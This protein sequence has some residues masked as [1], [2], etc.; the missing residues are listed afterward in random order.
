LTNILRDID[1]DAAIGRLYLPRE[2]LAEAG[3]TTTDPVAAIASPNIG[4]AC[5]PVIARAQSHFAQSQA[6]MAANPRR[7]VKTPRI[8]AAAYRIYL[9]RMI[10]RGWQAPRERVRLKR[11]QFLWILLRFAIV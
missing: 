3:I 4:Q 5:A 7:A 6:I 11:W 10:A 8:M 2:A 9:D 1:E